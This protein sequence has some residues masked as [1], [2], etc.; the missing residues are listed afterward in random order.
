MIPFLHGLNAMGFALAGLYFLRFWKQTHDPFFIWFAVGFWLFALNYVAAAAFS[1]NDASP[2]AYI[3]RLVG[4]GLIVVAILSKNVG[5][6]Q[7]PGQ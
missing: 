7:N 6:R 5:R 2:A 3:L 1:A 4:F